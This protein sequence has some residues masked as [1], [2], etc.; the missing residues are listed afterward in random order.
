MLNCVQVSKQWNFKM[1]QKSKFYLLRRIHNNLNR[2]LL[3]AQAEFPYSMAPSIVHP[4]KYRGL[5]K[6]DELGLE[7]F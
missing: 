5:C 3:R 7:F 6:T 2:V 4:K 1:N